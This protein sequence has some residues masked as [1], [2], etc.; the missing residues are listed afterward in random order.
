MHQSKTI[1]RC[2]KYTATKCSARCHTIN[3]EIVHI[4]EIHNHESELCQVECRKV[5]NNIK[6]KALSSMANTSQIISECTR[7]L[8]RS[9]CV[10][11]P[12]LQSIKRT[13][14]NVRHRNNQVPLNPISLEELVI[15]ERYRTTHTNHN[16]YMFDNHSANRI[17]I[18]STIEN[19]QLLK[20]NK[21]WF[22][23]GTFK[24]CPNLFSQLYTIHFLK[25]NLCFPAVYALMGRRSINSYNDLFSFINGSIMNEFPQ[26]ITFD[27]ELAAI[28]SS[29]NIFPQTSVHGCF[30]HFNQCL[31]KR[32]QQN[33]ILLHR[34]NSE[35]E[36]KENI[37]MI[38]AISFVPVNHII[39]AYNS[40]ISIPFYV[41]NQNHLSDFLSYVVDTWIG[42]NNEIGLITPRFPHEQW[43]CYSRVIGGLPLSNNSVEGWHHSFNRHVGSS[44]PSIWTFIEKL[45][46]QQS[47]TEF[48][49]NQVSAGIQIRKQKI[50]YKQRYLRLARLVQQYNSLP[51]ILF[52][53]GISSNISF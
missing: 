49:L 33:P 41:E 42:K 16:F 2:S 39:F 31:W 32:I 3:N 51:I 21:N 43:S 1:W 11:M 23:D 6:A 52:L 26:S 46:D 37:K 44:H 35:M 18:F 28:S 17:I 4:Y 30:F 5:V 25:G 24:V 10:S 53:R 8:P 40:L 29:K 20:E 47:Q 12:S 19:L 45:K 38:A 13:I 22:C 27:F 50:K 14:Q 36:F 7:N 15:P 48:E 34:Y 9:V